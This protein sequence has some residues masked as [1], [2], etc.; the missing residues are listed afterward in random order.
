[1]S[2]Q[3]FDDDSFN[4]AQ[5]NGRV[6]TSRGNTFTVSCKVNTP[7]AGIVT[8]KGFQEDAPLTPEFDCIIIAASHQYLP[9]W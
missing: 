6:V 9:V 5:A 1:M 7:H 8:D 3:N 4:T 2:L